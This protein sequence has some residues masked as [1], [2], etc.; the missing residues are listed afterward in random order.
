MNKSAM[1]DA[2]AD[3]GGVR[4]RCKVDAGAGDFNGLGA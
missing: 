4:E 1:T 3:G 2:S